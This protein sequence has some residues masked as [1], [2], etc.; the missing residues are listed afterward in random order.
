IKIGLIID[1]GEPGRI[2]GARMRECDGDDDQKGQQRDAQARETRGVPAIE[3]SHHSRLVRS[4]SVIGRADA[5]WGWRSRLSRRFL[6]AC[7]VEARPQWDLRT[8][9]RVFLL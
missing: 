7:A 9:P 5:L 3:N 2:G 4:R 1:A 6:I 8:F